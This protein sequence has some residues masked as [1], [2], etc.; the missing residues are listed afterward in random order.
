MLN[1]HGSK[2]KRKAPARKRKAS[3]RKAAPRRRSKPKKRQSSKQKSAAKKM[4]AGLTRKINARGGAW[5]KRKK[6]LYKKALLALDRKKKIKISP[7][8]KTALKASVKRS[9]YA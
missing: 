5:V 8:I 2:K 6:A 1:L 4:F 3:T 7:K 9:K